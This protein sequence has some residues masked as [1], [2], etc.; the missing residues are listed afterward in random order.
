VSQNRTERNGNVLPTPIL[1]EVLR[2]SSEAKAEDGKDKEG[3]ISPF[4]KIFGG[5][6]LSITAMVVVTAYQ[7]LNSTFGDLRNEMGHSA[8]EMRKELTSVSEAQSALVKK[9]DMTR[10]NTSVWA[11]ITEL[12]AERDNLATLK[13]RCATLKEQIK[14]GEA[15]RRQLAG[16]L[17]KLR[18]HKAAADE[19][20]ALVR[21]VQALREKLAQ[22]E[23][24]RVANLTM[25]KDGE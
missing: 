8:K 21:E 11:A 25:Q 22:L 12:R 2:Q 19:R 1:S 24:A 16:E 3:P 9:D 20:Q 5:T 4:W 7:G 15:E 23:S 17:Q 13:E 6:V 14:A 10:A 18:E